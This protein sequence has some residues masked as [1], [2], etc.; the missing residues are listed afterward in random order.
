M[1]VHVSFGFIV[2]SK[3]FCLTHWHLWV[4]NHVLLITCL[5]LLHDTTIPEP[6]ASWKHQVP[7]SQ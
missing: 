1:R 4:N 3:A 6:S 5:F 2:S 7:S